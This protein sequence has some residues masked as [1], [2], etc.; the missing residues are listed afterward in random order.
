MKKLFFTALVAVVAV[1]GA[2]SVNATT[3]YKLDG[4][5]AVECLQDA[6]IQCSE[7]VSAN[8]PVYISPT[9]ANDPTRA[10]PSSLILE[11]TFYNQ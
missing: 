9:P 1:G 7:Y 8:G 6:D 5:V 10:Q 11:S 3:Y 4:S 2:F